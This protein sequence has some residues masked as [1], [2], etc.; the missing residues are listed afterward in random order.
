[1]LVL[2]DGHMPSLDHRAPS[3]ESERRQEGYRLFWD[4]TRGMLGRYSVFRI[5]LPERYLSYP[6][7]LELWYG[8]CYRYCVW[9]V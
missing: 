6:V 4:Q 1:M 9:G 7:V 3:H 2:W 8:W 5:C